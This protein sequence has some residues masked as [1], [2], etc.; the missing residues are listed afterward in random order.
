MQTCH[1]KIK[2]SMNY[3]MERVRV[4]TPPTQMKHMRTKVCKIS[5]HVNE[6]LMTKFANML[7]DEPMCARVHS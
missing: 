1:A 7:L 2:R 3:S 4:A 6:D 5:V